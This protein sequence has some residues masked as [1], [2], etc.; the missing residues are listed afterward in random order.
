MT[1]FLG[2]FGWQGLLFLGPLALASVCCLYK[3]RTDPR[4]LAFFWTS[5]WV[6]LA[7]RTFDVWWDEESQGMVGG[8][9]GLWLLNFELSEPDLVATIAVVLGWADLVAI[10][11]LLRHAKRLPLAWLISAL[12]ACMIFGYALAAVE[13]IEG[14]TA[15][16]VASLLGIIKLF[17]IIGGAT[18]GLKLVSDRLRRSS[19]YS[20][21][22]D[23][24]VVLQEWLDAKETTPGDAKMAR[25]HQ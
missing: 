6:W 12:Y 22:A 18:G 9:V 19:R 2:P 20:G 25:H 24:L 4:Y 8:F 5:L 10:V 7:A 16:S 3:A 13:M 14:G 1:A 23:R 17:A 11:V 21:L 15:V